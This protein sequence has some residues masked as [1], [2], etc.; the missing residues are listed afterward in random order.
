MRGTPGT[1]PRSGSLRK[2][3]HTPPRFTS[4]VI[5][6]RRQS[7]FPRQVDLLLFGLPVPFY[8]A[9]CATVHQVLPCHKAAAHPLA[10]LRYPEKH[11]NPPP[12]SP[13]KLLFVCVRN[14]HVARDGT[15][16]VVPLFETCVTYFVVGWW[17]RTTGLGW[18]GGVV[19]LPRA[20]ALYLPS[21]AHSFSGDD[22]PTHLPSRPLDNSPRE[23]VRTV[24]GR[25]IEGA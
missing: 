22:R 9:F 25:L 18:S 16:R 2:T 14:P 5:R 23:R 17:L 19:P 8:V 1:S 4:C 21:P 15:T 13:R 3:T 10:L 7:L 12:C 20:A 6:N 11:S 24:H